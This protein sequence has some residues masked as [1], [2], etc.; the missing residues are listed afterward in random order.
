MCIDQKQSLILSPSSYTCMVFSFSVSIL[1]RLEFPHV[2]LVRPLALR[3]GIRAPLNH[4][5]GLTQYGPTIA[6]VYFNA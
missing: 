3:K 4:V 5:D 2:Q 1:L 6:I